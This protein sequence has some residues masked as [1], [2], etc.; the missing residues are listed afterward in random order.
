MKFDAKNLPNDLKKRLKSA[1]YQDVSK[2][3]TLMVVDGKKVVEIN[4][5]WDIFAHNFDH[6]GSEKKLIV[7]IKKG[8]GD[9]YENILK[10]FMGWAF[11]D[12]GTDVY[13]DK[14]K[15]EKKGGYWLVKPGFLRESDGSIFLCKPKIFPVGFTID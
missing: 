13:I 2:D 12:M 14:Y 10:S 5:E 9:L 1:G 8:S 6:L 7:A 15:D 11:G 4:Y 3:L